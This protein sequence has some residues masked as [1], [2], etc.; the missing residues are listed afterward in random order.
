MLPNGSDAAPT[1]GDD[2]S[3]GT[4]NRMRDLEKRMIDE[5]A[6]T[7]TPKVPENPYL[8]IVK[9]APD[10]K[11]PGLLE[12]FCRRYGMKYSGG[13]IREWLLFQIDET[14]KIEKANP[15]YYRVTVPEVPEVPPDMEAAA[16]EAYER[17]Y[18][19]RQAFVAAHSNDNCTDYGNADRFLN[20]YGLDVKYCAAFDS[21]YI[22]NHP[23]GRWRRDGMG[24][25]QELAKKTIMSIFKESE[26]CGFGSDRGKILAKWAFECQTMSH[27]TAVLKLSCSDPWVAVPPETFDR[28][29]YL[30]NM[31]NGVYD[32]L[33]H[34]LFP[35]SKERLISQSTG[36]T[37]DATATCPLVEKFL[38]RIFLS[39]PNK[40]AIILFVQKAVGYSLTG[41]THEQV[42]F[43]LYGK[44]QNGKSVLLSVID[45]LLGDYAYTADSSSFTTAKTDKVRNDIAAFVGKRFIQ[46][47]EITKTAILDEALIKKL[48]GG[49]NITAR[50]LFKEDF[51]FTPIMKLWLAFNHRPDI[52]DRTYSIWRR[53]LLIPFEETIPEEEQ[54]RQLA[55]K[56]AAELPGIMNW[57]IEGLKRY[58]AEGLNPPQC[59]KS[60]TEEYRHDTD[61]LYDFISVILE[62]GD[63]THY[64]YS[65]ELYSAYRQW[66]SFN[67]ELDKN[68]MSSTKFGK[69]LTERFRKDRDKRGVLY[70]GVRIKCEMIAKISSDPTNSTSRTGGLP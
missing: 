58:Q 29:P 61:A 63:P 55:G 66:C 6:I 20:L 27:T 4:L 24:E 35:H 41:L 28:D 46:S 57:A 48:T 31:M 53:I 62:I 36:I 34:K 50:F 70:Y 17:K 15:E 18:N 23:E 26:R 67:H 54:D 12:S 22:W 9:N 65:S 64:E 43:L 59:V 33:N 19:E 25:I 10:N 45:K 3:D 38:D 37:Y 69:E 11:L 44:G 5:G 49:E 14:I 13:D 30:L 39:N 2:A 52:R 51:T 47:S 40:D 1:P 56:L 7:I 21:W 32:L 16:L 60:A 42:L 68:I 8:T